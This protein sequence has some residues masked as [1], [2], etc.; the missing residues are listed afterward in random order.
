ML[1]AKAGRAAIRLANGVVDTIVL[2]VGLALLAFGCYA[3]WD[4]SQVVRAAGAAQYQAYKPTADIPAPDGVSPLAKLQA[5]NPDVT[6]WLTVDGTNIDYP[7]V[8]GKDNVRY[9]TTDAK[10][11]HSVSGSIFIDYRNSANFSDFATIIYGHHMKS[12]AMFGEI[13]MYHQR[14]FFDA[15]KHGA[16]YFDG[17][18]H[19]IEFFAFVHT[20]AYDD[21][22]YTTPVAA[23][24]RQH[25]IDTLTRE[26]KF[27]QNDISVSADDHIVVLSTCSSI[28]TNGRDVLIGKIVDHPIERPAKAPSGPVGQPSAHSLPDMLA[29]VPMWTKLMAVVVPLG[30]VLALTLVIASMRR[31]ARGKYRAR[32]GAE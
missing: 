14:D 29:Q 7:V 22:I 32:R 20:S 30:L 8:H 3:I 23:I 11:Q 26:A 31:R 6:G 25:Y 28:T 16:L 19:G 4:A 24:G 12:R 21:T 9:L 18:Q 13:D 15:H 10:G 27:V 17:R 1:A 5:M 2:V